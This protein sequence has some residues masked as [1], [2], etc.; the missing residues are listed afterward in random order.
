ML[1]CSF[2]S[3]FLKNRIR[4]PAPLILLLGCTLIEIGNV[5]GDEYL[6]IGEKVNPYCYDSFDNNQCTYMENLIKVITSKLEN[7]LEQKKIS[8]EEKILHVLDHGIE[9]FWGL[10]DDRFVQME[11]ERKQSY[12]HDMSSFKKEMQN[13]VKDIKRQSWI[14]NKQDRYLSLG[15]HGDDANLTMV[16]RYQSTKNI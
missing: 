10:I 14:E 2:L 1:C 5:T 6:N 3:A 13:E 12:L 9:Y 15:I 4:L 16:R 8:L 11:E 7:H